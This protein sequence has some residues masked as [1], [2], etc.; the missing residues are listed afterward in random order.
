MIVGRVRSSCCCVWGERGV[1]CSRGR[2]AE[3][4]SRS[5][6]SEPDAV[7]LNVTAIYINDRQHRCPLSLI[8][9]TVAASGAHH[10]GP[11]QAGFHSSG[12]DLWWQG[13]Q[14]RQRVDM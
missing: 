5:S 8:E 6:G 7:R 14:A 1:V 2:A 13:L 3:L 12:H 9:A 4:W 10:V 11:A